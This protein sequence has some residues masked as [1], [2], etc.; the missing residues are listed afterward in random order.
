MARIVRAISAAVTFLCWSHLAGGIIAA[1]WPTVLLATGL[2]SIASGIIAVSAATILMAFGGAGKQAGTDVT[3]L[4]SA[5]VT[6]EMLFASVSVWAAGIGGFGLTFAGA[7][8]VV[9][10]AAFVVGRLGAR[11]GSA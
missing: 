9:L 10:C 7:A 8:V 11:L 5:N 2:L 1:S 4:Q 6:G 3:V